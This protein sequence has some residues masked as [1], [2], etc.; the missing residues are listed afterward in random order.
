MLLD[1][2]REK[3]FNAIAY[4]VTHTNGC[5]KTKLFKLLYL[6]DFQHYQETGRPVTGLDYY[7]WPKGPVPRAL[8]QELDNPSADLS[9]RFTV[10][11]KKT[12]SWNALVVQPN[13]PF[14]DM[15]FSKRE[16]R[17]MENLA[18]EFHDATANRMVEETHL[19]NRPWHTVYQEQG[20]R[21]AIIPYSLAIRA[22]ERREMEELIQDRQEFLAEFGA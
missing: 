3:L 2:A 20:N 7:A 13:F 8:Y 22:S 6:L 18:R 19:E 10:A 5:Y 16:L 9:Q 11:K 15:I 21:Q 14:N 4:F 1:F 17:I 12:G